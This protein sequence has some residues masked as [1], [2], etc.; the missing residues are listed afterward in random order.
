MLGITAVNHHFKNIIIYS[1][2]WQPLPAR[3]LSTSKLR[4]ILDR[5]SSIHV[6]YFRSAAKLCWAFLF[7]PLIACAYQTLLFSSSLVPGAFFR[8]CFNACHHCQGDFDCSNSLPKASAWIYV[9]PHPNHLSSEHGSP[10]P[11][12]P[13]PPPPA[14]CLLRMR[15]PGGG[16]M[17]PEL[18]RSIIKYYMPPHS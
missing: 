1:L 7:L 16:Y 14:S 8:A 12:P 5:I 2:P 10:P 18:I 13:P 11:P 6:T 15:I 9:P 17:A 4:C 3:L